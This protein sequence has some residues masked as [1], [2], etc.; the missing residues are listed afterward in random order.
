MDYFHSTINSI[1]IANVSRFIC[2]TI[3]YKKYFNIMIILV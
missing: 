1:F 3:I 2:R